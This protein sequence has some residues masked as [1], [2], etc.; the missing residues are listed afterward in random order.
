MLAN[1]TIAE[2]GSYQDLLQR[3]GALVGLLD[4]ARQPAGEGEGRIVWASLSLCAWLPLGEGC[5]GPTDVS[6]VLN[7]THLEGP[8]GT[9]VLHTGHT[10][11]QRRSRGH[12]L[13]PPVSLIILLTLCMFMCVGVHVCSSVLTYVV[14][15]R[16]R[17]SAVSLSSS[18]SCFQGLL[19]GSK[20]P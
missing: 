5:K 18:P 16:R 8:P 12:C 6:A 13:G 10:P 9:A 3:N 2:M 4:G 17:I 11:P 7:H 19:L 1:G 15:G 20:A 14:G